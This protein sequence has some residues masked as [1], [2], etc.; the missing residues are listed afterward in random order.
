VRCSD[1]NEVVR[2]LAVDARPRRRGTL[3]L[4]MA[5]SGRTP[6]PRCP[7]PRCNR[8][9]R[10]R[11]YGTSAAIASRRGC[12]VR[13]RSPGITRRHSGVGHIGAGDGRPVPADGP[14]AAVLLR[15]LSRLG[16]TTTA[17]AT[18]SRDLTGLPRS[19]GLADPKIPARDPSV[20]R[21]CCRRA[22]CPL[23]AV[24]PSCRI[25]LSDSPNLGVL[26]E[27]LNLVQNY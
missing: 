22:T 2:L 12:R 19:S 25:G 6:A 21:S 18:T 4:S 9:T 10:R 14:S 13:L 23:L 24:S 27:S 15:R 8:R 1:A 26:C 5:R 17:R 7:A 3:S 16:R 11:P 20:R